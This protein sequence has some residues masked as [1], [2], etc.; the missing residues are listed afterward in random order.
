[1]IAETV[2]VGD[3]MMDNDRRNL[4]GLFKVVDKRVVLKHGNKHTV[5]LLY[6]YGKFRSVAY[7]TLKKW[8]ILLDRD[9]GRPQKARGNFEKTKRSILSGTDAQREVG[10]W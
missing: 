9:R 3:I 7:S 6:G 4:G 8:F 10:Y 1:M 2:Q 5:V